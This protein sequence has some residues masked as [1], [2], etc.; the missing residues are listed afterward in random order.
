MNN[1]EDKKVLPKEGAIS[2]EESGK[3]ID[4]FGRLPDAPGSSYGY[5]INS[6]MEP[7]NRHPGFGDASL[8]HR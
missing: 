7:V 4:H 1:K 3:N 8:R 5:S 2:N 6:N